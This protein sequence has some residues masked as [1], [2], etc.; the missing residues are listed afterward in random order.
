MEKA[1][2]DLFKGDLFHSTVSDSAMSDLRVMKKGGAYRLRNGRY[3][4]MSDALA[5]K[6]SHRIA[7][8]EFE[9]DKYMR[10]Y[11]SVCERLSSVER[12]LRD[13]KSNIG[14]LIK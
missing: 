11:L 9:R 2:F 10:A 12:E 3:A 1:R 4:S 8:L 13:M 5:D 14:K 6:Y 7:W